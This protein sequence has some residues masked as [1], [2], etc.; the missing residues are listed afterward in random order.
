[1]IGNKYMT[2]S[3]IRSN[4]L[5][6]FLFVCS[7]S[8]PIIAQEEVEEFTEEDYTEE[9]YRAKV[10]EF[11]ID[12]VFPVN[13]FGRVLDRDLFGL[14]LSYLVERDSDQYDFF[15]FQL[16]YTHIGAISNNLIVP[17]QSGQIEISERTGSNFLG[18]HFIYRYYLPF[19]FWKVEPFAEAS[20]GTNMFYTSTSTTFYDAEETT[21]FDV[22]EFDM[23]ISF[24]LSTGFTLHLTS[25]SFIVAKLYYY[26]GNAISY[27]IDDEETEE[28]SID[29]FR[30]E[31]SQT[32]HLRLQLGISYTFL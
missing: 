6:F 16:S 9:D 15:G 30:N 27:T 31:T 4:I 23:G 24:G 11:T 14:S 25:Q 21:D 13:T 19:F 22:N 8:N 7:F 12:P 2:S 1:M 3:G 10:V 20:F 26:S 5:L 17:G 32:N 28:I 18:A 29:N